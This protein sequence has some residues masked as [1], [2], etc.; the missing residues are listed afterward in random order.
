MKRTDFDLAAGLVDRMDK[1]EKIIF[2]LQELQKFKEFVIIAPIIPIN[3]SIADPS[4]SNEYAVELREGEMATEIFLQDIL[5]YYINTLNLELNDL[6][7]S[8]DEI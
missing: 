2:K 7:K 5:E 3:S 6:R 8:F 1:L 4:I